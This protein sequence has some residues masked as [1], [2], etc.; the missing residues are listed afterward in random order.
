M[1][2][3]AIVPSD[4]G[5]RIGQLR[6]QRRWSQAH[7]AVEVGVTRDRVTCWENGRA[8]PRLATV[9]LLAD[10]FETTTD[11]LLRGRS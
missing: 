4:F 5:T 3:T 11:Y 2:V 6:E 10:L 8:L 9:C 7:L 1:S